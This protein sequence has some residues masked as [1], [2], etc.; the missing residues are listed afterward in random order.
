M[1]PFFP[2]IKVFVNI[3]FKHRS[4]KYNQYVGQFAISNVQYAMPLTKFF[5]SLIHSI[6]MCYNKFVISWDNDI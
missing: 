2:M 1:H 3:N 5:F 6:I 4:Q